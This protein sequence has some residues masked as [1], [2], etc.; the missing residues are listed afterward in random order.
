M[1]IG[2]EGGFT[3]LRKSVNSQIHPDWIQEENGDWVT[4][5]PTM[6]RTV[7]ANDIRPDAKAAWVS[8]FAGRKKDAN[9]IYH[10]ES[11][12]DL[13][14]EARSG[15]RVFPEGVGIVTGGFPCQD[16]SI[17]GK[18]LGFDSQRSHLGS[19]LADDEP[20]EESRGKLYM[21]GHQL[22]DRLENK[23]DLK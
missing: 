21:I 1:D 4:L 5:A 6:F 15:K 11:V 23:I 13:V 16:F 22:V 20:S 8:Y 18:R 10:L 2:F 17:A 7:F 14:K 19:A 12:V 3:C 9:N